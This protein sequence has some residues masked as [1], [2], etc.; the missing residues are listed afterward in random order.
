MDRTGGW[1]YQDFPSKNFCLTVPKVFLEESSTVAVNSG[2]GKVW[3]TGGGGGGRSRFSVENFS[4]HS[5]KNFRT[6]ILCCINFGY[7]K[8]LEEKGGVSRFSV[9]KFISHSAE[10]FCRG[11]FRCC[12]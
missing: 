2:T 10:K 5:A 6:G 4:S 1:E 9:E 8:K 11:I 3:I 12:K 7:R